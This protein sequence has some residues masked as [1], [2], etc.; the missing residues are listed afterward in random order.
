M[1]RLPVT[2]EIP[3]RNVH[4]PRQV[5]GIPTD[6][7]LIAMVNQVDA[8]AVAKHQV[9]LIAP[10]HLLTRV[11]NF[12]IQQLNAVDLSERQR[13]AEQLSQPRKLIEP[14]QPWQTQSNFCSI[15]INNDGTIQQNQCD[16]ASHQNLHK[17]LD[18]PPFIRTIDVE[19]VAQKADN[20]CIAKN[21]Q[22][23]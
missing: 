11:S 6:L 16:A 21:Q 4:H 20:Q 1:R 13:T 17:R 12:F 9:E 2:N 3:D 10:K 19:F 7:P 14:P 15:S 22:R 8:L 23:Q 18:H 5:T